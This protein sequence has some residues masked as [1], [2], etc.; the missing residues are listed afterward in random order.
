MH[1]FLEVARPLAEKAA[2]RLTELLKQPLTQERKTDRSWVTNADYEADSIIRQGLQQ[3]FPDHAILTEESAL[4]GL[5]NAEYVWVVDPLDGTRSFIRGTPGYSVMVGLLRH[6]IPYAGV[7]V[8]PVEQRTYEAL[9]GMGAYETYLG[10]RDALRV[11]KRNAWDDLRI[12]TSTGFPESLRKS[13]R[14]EWKGQWLSPINSVGIKVGLVVRQE[15]D[16]YINHHGVHYW[17]TCAPQLILE[18]AGGVM[19]YG[20]GTPLTYVLDGQYMHKGWT[21]VSNGTRHDDALRI[22]RPLMP[23]VSSSKTPTRGH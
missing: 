12:V 4:H 21:L 17:D 18:E 1:P 5:P 20:D 7:V 13:L 15:A 14:L 22:A 3:A 23:A 11:S 19:T 6:G 8:D 16:I 9:H 2:A 10:K